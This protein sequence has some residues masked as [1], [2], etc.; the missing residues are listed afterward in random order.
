[1][2]HSEMLLAVAGLSEAEI[3]QRTQ[4]LSSGDWSAFP[5]AERI[6]YRFAYRV[7]REPAAVTDAD[8]RDLVGTFGPERTADLIW[9]GG[10]CNY[11]TRVADAFQ[12]PLEKE[13][14]FARPAV[15]QPASDG[16]SRR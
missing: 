1:M 14:V 15:A 16:K 7:T 9:Y 13:N 8:V 4:R 2:G 10:W 11:M 3:K 6:A 5:P 12:L